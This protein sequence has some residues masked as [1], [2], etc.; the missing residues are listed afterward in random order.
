MSPVYLFEP[1]LLRPIM[2]PCV[3]KI[4]SNAYTLQTRAS[5]IGSVPLLPLTFPS[6]HRSSHAGT[7]F[8][9]VSP[10]IPCRHTPVR[11][12]IPPR[13]VRA[14]GHSWSCSISFAKPQSAHSS[15]T[16]N[17]HQAHSWS[18]HGHTTGAVLAV[19]AGGG[20]R[21][22]DPP[23]RLVRAQCHQTLDGCLGHCR[24]LEVWLN[25]RPTA[26]LTLH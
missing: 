16:R 17:F 23:R 14:Y 11:A 12:H 15:N 7:Y 6:C 9:L 1:N 13:H 4:A 26:Q 18:H 24:A 5:S 25:R 10:V 20:C 2:P 22:F 8:P 21:L 3:R 19:P